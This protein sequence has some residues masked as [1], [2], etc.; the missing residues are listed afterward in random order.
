MGPAA[1][2]IAW[3][4]LALAWAPCAPAEGVLY[5]LPYA[6]G[7]AFMISQAPGGM[8]STHTTDY[9]RHAVDFS[10]PEG[11]PVAAAR[12]GI[13]IEAE[14]RNTT[15]ARSGALLTKGNLVRV[16]HPDGSIGSYAH[17]M[18]AGVAVEVGEA[19]QAGRI[20][21]YSGS[22]GYSS[23]PHL[24]F[25]VTRM[26]MARPGEA[27]EEVSEPVTFYNGNPPVAFAPRAGLAV[28]ANY[29]S[30]AD[31]PAPPRAAPAAAPGTAPTLEELAEG[32]A[33]LAAMIV[34]A[35]AGI[36][37]FYRFSRR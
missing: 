11:T 27:L 31:P 22:T 28:T 30:P 6:E 18:H 7:R 35:L 10:M 13:V 32:W 24:H 23:G 8:I 12:E 9:S 19:V 37:W 16:R 20:L 3:L 25:A 15:G 1:R 34:V 33:R 4:A 29:A 26:A 2:W 5:R 36:A 17:L 21:G 14:W